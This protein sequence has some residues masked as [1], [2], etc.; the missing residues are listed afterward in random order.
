MENL[1]FS[2]SL[3]NKIQ[4]MTFFNSKKKKKTF[5]SLLFHYFSEKVE[6]TN[7]SPIFKINTYMGF[8]S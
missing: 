2:I 4:K 8:I 3:K 1:F 7:K 6:F 5:V